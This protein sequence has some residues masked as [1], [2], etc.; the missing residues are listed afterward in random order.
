MKKV[1]EK[2]TI[3]ANGVA[4][5]DKI[6]AT[7]IHYELAPFAQY[8][9]GVQITFLP[10]RKKVRMMIQVGFEPKIVILEGW[11]H[12]DSPSAFVESNPRIK[13]IIS[14]KTLNISKE[15]FIENDAKFELFLKK[16]ISTNQAKI[17]I[18]TRGFIPRT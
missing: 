12:P 3:Y 7:N 14:L 16:Y 9:D 2:G 15:A 1:I 4:G 18:D 10:K 11:G 6:E 5:Y 17:L 8:L 13:G